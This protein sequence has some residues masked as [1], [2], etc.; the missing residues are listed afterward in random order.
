MGVYTPVQYS[1]Y[2]SL[3]FIKPKKEGTVRFIIDYY[4]LNH[5]LMRNP[6]PLPRIGQTMKHMEGFQYTTALYLN[7]GYSTISILPASQEMTT[8]VI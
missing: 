6:Y 7:M 2:G 8:I 3:V 4:K 5:Q 1:Y